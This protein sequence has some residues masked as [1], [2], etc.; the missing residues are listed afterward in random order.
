MRYLVAAANAIDACPDG[1]ERWLLGSA[2]AAVASE[3]YSTGRLRRTSTFIQSVAAS[4]QPIELANTATCPRRCAAVA[5]S[6]DATPA[7][8][9]TPASSAVLAVLAG[10][11]NVWSAE[12][13]TP[14]SDAGSHGAVDPQDGPLSGA[15]SPRGSRRPRRPR[16]PTPR[17]P[18]AH[19]TALA[20]APTG[21]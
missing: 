20:P 3:V 10:P 5:P 11:E 17:P 13:S 21:R 4:V 14:G 18:N 15:S 8:P 9:I 12:R 2:A 1:N 7:N 6:N 16:P 19:C